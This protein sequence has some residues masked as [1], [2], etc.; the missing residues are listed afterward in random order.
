[1]KNWKI[2]PMNNIKALNILSLGFLCLI[3][4]AAMAST[5]VSACKEIQWEPYQV[6]SVSS[7]LHQRTHIILPEPIQGVPV[8]G[9]PQLWDVDGENVH[10]FIKPKNLGN[11]EGGNTT[12]TAISTTNNSYDFTVRRVKNNP[13]IC[14]RIVRENFKPMGEKQG[15]AYPEQRINVALEQEISTLKT[16]LQDTEASK[17]RAV[18]DAL[19]AYRSNV[20]TG[21][22]W[23]G[24][25]GF[26]G[27]DGIS[28]I[29]DDGR[30][31]FVRPVN[32]NNGL[33]AVTAMVNGKE[34]MADYKWDPSAKLYMITG[35]YP[36]FVMR[37]DGSTITV[38]RA[39][40]SE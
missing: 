9:N 11:K 24:G 21:Y 28:D 33:L 1:M 31:I 5:V 6:Y 20:F 12:V 29:W 17:G 18:E 34:E 22:K 16:R 39:S 36:E 10:L 13:D 8:P 27:G 4:S 14:I 37:D 7:S 25:G 35:L 26:Y 32:P 30:F 15:W 3:N 2:P 19:M 23:S 38:T 40:E